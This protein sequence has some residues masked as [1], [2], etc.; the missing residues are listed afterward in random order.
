MHELMVLA[1]TSDG[2]PSNLLL[3]RLAIRRIMQV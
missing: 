2:A 3:A 1:E